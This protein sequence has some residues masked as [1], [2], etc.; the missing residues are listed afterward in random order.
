MKQSHRNR[1]RQAAKAEKRSLGK[2]KVSK[3]AA[4]RGVIEPGENP[5]LPEEYR[6]RLA[7][8]FK[9]DT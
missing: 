2:P 9:G 1:A 8:H 5:F 3:Y 7:S 4:K 6:D